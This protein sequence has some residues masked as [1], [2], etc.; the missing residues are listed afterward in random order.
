M[1]KM[2][3]L[4]IAYGLAPMVARYGMSPMGL[5]LLPRQSFT[6]GVSPA[7]IAIA[8]LFIASLLRAESRAKPLIFLAAA[9][10]LYGSW[11]INMHHYW[12]ANGSAEQATALKSALLLSLPFQAMTYFV[13]RQCIQKLKRQLSNKAGRS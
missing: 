2:M 10:V 3:L 1:L 6:W 13:A 8:A 12:V 4:L 11:F 9:L 5:L 7:W